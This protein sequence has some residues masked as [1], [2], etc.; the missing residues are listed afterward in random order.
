MLFRSSP[1]EAVIHILDL[2]EAWA[3]T[4]G[5]TDWMSQE[6]AKWE[7]EKMKRRRDRKRKQRKK[8]T[9]PK[10]PR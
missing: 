9:R 3:E 1:E 5:F 8:A 6:Y 10:R 2:Q 4:E 7:G